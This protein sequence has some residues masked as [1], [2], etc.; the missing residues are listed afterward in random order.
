LPEIG[1]V[2]LIQPVEQMS[3]SLTKLGSCPIWLLVAKSQALLGSKIRSVE[4]KREN[5][6][7]HQYPSGG[8]QAACQ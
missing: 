2:S 4:I 3:V 6:L 5:G 7:R 8:L 1:A